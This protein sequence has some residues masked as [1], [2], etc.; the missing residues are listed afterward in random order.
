MIIYF[1][2]THLK[3][4]KNTFALGTAII[5]SV[6][7]LPLFNTL[8]QKQAVVLAQ[9]TDNNTPR[10]EFT[11]IAHNAQLDMDSEAPGK[12]SIVWTYN[13]TVPGPTI[14]VT[15][16]DL[17]TIHFINH[18]DMAHTIHFHGDH[19]M[20]N[21]GVDPLVLVGGN[22]NYS[23]T[24]E[25]R[26][27]LLYHCHM[28]PTSQ[29]IRMGMYGAIIV[30]PKE[31]Q[32]QLPPAREFLLVMSEHDPSDKDNT[33]P[34][35][36]PAYYLINGYSNVY[37][38]HPLQANYTETVRFY[39]INIG[40]TIP[41]SFHLHSATF[42]AY[43]SGLTANTPINAQSWSI[44]PGDAAIIDAK[45]KY[46]GTYLFHSHGIQE[47]HGNMGKINISGSTAKPLNQ[48]ISM[49]DWQYQ[50]QKKLQNSH[51]EIPQNPHN[52]HAPQNPHTSSNNT[53]SIVVNA[54]LP[55]RELFYS[56]SPST[57]SNGTM[58]NWT[59]YDTTDHTVTSKPSSPSMFD[60]NSIARGHKFTHVFSTP[61]IYNY[62]CK[63]HPFMTGQ[64]IVK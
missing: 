39:V 29:H 24:A 60:S 55:N 26:G 25:P 21:D 38:N 23:F 27:L 57:V 63:I 46:P 12:D 17:V 32:N 22:Y 33:S 8:I 62:F 52:P 28:M 48:S 40:V 54:S 53:I 41:Y 7:L 37:Y 10:K 16:G 5:F 31:K 51:P 4:M 36:E 15:E 43:P 49:I 2:T 1:A 14:R 56:P 6:L 44:G 50:L 64:V 11:L 42:K 45:W 59:N 3:R 47:E 30:D 9:A 61:G 58:V 20:E 19:A 34:K 35:F 13:G 18:G